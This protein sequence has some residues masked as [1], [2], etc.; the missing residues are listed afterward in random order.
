LYIM[1][2]DHPTIGEIAEDE[3]G[4]LHLQV[5]ELKSCCSEGRDLLLICETANLQQPQL[6]AEG[7]ENGAD[8][9]RNTRPILFGSVG[10]A[11]H[12]RSSI[13]LLVSP[14]GLRPYRWLLPN[15]T[16]T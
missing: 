14:A 9:Q 15:W 5:V 10:I 12:E 7:K 3:T 11:P 1:E 8:G 13:P 6:M 2:L 4:D 16:L